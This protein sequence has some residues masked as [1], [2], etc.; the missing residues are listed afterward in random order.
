MR[1]F[2]WSILF[3][4]VASPS[5]SW[6]T[7][8]DDCK[9]AADQTEEW[10]T[11]PRWRDGSSYADVARRTDPDKD[12]IPQFERAV[13]HPLWDYAWVPNLQER[14]R[15]RDIH[16][17]IWNF[18]QAAKRPGADKEELARQVVPYVR[19]AEMVDT[20][21]LALGEIGHPSSAEVLIAEIQKD[22]DVVGTDEH[23]QEFVHKYAAWVPMA[24]GSLDY[25]REPRLYLRVEETLFKLREAQTKVRFSIGLTLYDGLTALKSSRF[26]D[27]LRAELRDQKNIWQTARAISTLNE[28]QFIEPLYQAATNA[29]DE[30]DFM[31]LVRTLAQMRGFYGQRG[32]DA[33]AI[34]A[35]LAKSLA[36]KRFLLNGDVAIALA[37]I[38]PTDCGS[39]K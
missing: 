28:W 8:R 26:R 33:Y 32:I 34:F 7:S 38:K 19:D 36:E 17:R 21:T 35:G 27:L 22:I 6:G 24:L 2:I 4:A 15:R 5:L 1:S 23:Y 9:A 29:R 13:T 20:A 12:R 39:W 18:V 30:R 37:H 10:L 11:S 31:A 14:A 16:Q 3:V 25:S